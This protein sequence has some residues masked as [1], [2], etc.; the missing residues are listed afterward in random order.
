[1]SPNDENNT[2][3]IKFNTP[4]GFGSGSDADAGNEHAHEPGAPS[5]IPPDMSDGIH[6]SGEP[7]RI[8]GSKKIRTIG[9][10]GKRHEEI[11]SRTPNATGTGALH[12]RTFHSKLSDESLRYLDQ[13]INEWLDSHPD[14]EVK[15]VTSNIGV[16]TGK[17]KEP[18]V[19]CSVW[20]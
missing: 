13:Q 16:F 11:W 12:V 4:S 7:T 14:Y 8:I 20:V 19:I 2:P 3:K 1:M 9:Q 6:D 10:K 18:A 17:I 15:F 5:S